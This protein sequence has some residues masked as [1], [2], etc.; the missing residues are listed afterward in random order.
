MTVKMVCMCSEYCLLNLTLKSHKKIISQT[1]S[2]D[3]QMGLKESRHAEN[4]VHRIV[5]LVTV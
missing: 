4:T 3:V 2:T 1:I 5:C